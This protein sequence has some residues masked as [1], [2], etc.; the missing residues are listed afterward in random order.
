MFA[1]LVDHLWQS[2]WICGA[3]TLLAIISRKDF[4][5]LRLW[6]WRIAAL[7]FLFPFALLVALGGWM[8]F[9]VKYPD[10][11]APPEMLATFRA[12][13]SLASPARVHEWSGWWLV[14]AMLLMLAISTLCAWWLKRQ[15]FLE[16]Q[17]VLEEARRLE[18]DRDDFAPRPGFFNSALLTACAL[19]FVAV[20][21]LAGGL[22]DRQRHYELLVSNSRSL[23][24]A[25]V[26]MTPAAPGM[27]SRFRIDAD[28]F[29][30][31]IR[32]VT[33]QELAGIAYGVTRYYVRGDHWRAEGAQDWF[34]VP[35]YDLRVTGRVLDPGRFDPLALRAR[36]TRMLAERHGLEIYVDS[37]CQPPCGK[38]G[39]PMPEAAF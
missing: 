35:R 33:I 15:L 5:P 11:A 24:D 10:D 27:G 8:G 17:R 32:N 22:E 19:L 36:I 16:Q 18:R 14:L 3:M 29:G 9:P 38:Y 34:I 25:A 21:V 37:K 6:M 31:F 23:R 13:T 12:L 1:G 39:V 7:K 20:P 30:V 2:A 28:E 26:T 4:A